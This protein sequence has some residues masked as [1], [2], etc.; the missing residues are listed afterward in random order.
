VQARR[1]IFKL[2]SWLGISSGFVLAV[3]GLSGLNLAFEEEILAALSPGI[4][5]LPPDPRPR[6][7]PYRLVARASAQRDGLRV[8]FLVMH[9]DPRLSPRVFFSPSA[10]IGA[11]SAPSYIDPVSGIL[12]GPA[13]GEHYFDFC[14]SLHRWLAL[15][16][17]ENGPGRTITGVAALTMVYFTCSGLYLRW[18]RRPWNWRPWLRLDL[19]Q[20]GT[21]FYR[22]LHSFTGTWVLI[23]YLFSASTG[24]W[25][26]FDWY[27]S[28]ARWALNSHPPVPVAVAAA[29][30]GATPTALEVAWQTL[31]RQGQDKYET[32]MMVLPVAAEPI[33]ITGFLANTTRDT[34]VDEYLFDARSGNLLHADFYATRSAGD[35]LAKSPVY[36]HRGSLFGLGGRIV[37]FVATLMLPL[38]PVTGL[39]LYLSRRS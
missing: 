39:I 36:V 10:T 12:L 16:G 33:R 23:V 14:E 30:R 17:R 3:M 11:S 6:L 31:Q 2:H 25:W 22:S 27:Q 38:F 5:T 24:L 32:F 26:A 21:M 34:S 9:R 19:R 8:F 4:V 28:L 7:T 1:L 37:V 20:K 13:H 29:A 35:I 15:P 18:P